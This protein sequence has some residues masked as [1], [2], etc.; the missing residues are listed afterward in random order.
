MNL[1]SDESEK[2][3]KKVISENKSSRKD[4]IFHKNKHKKDNSERKNSPY[5]AYSSNPNLTTNRFSVVEAYK[6]LRTNLQ[7]SMKKKGC[8]VIIITSTM[9]RD[10]K[11]TVAANI[12]VAF[13]Q[14]DIKV[15][16]IDCDMRKPRVNK[17]FN[18]PAIP[19]LSNLLAG[20][21]TLEQG[22]K[23]TEYKNLNI[24][25]SGILPP[26]P[27]ELLS[28]NDMKEL[29]DSLKNEYDL[30]I[31]D[32][33]PVNIVS[34]AI[35]ITAIADGV[36]LVVKHAVTT[37][38]DIERAIK[39]LEFVNAKLLGVVL[40]AVDYSKI[41]GKRYGYYYKGGKYGS[42]NRKDGYGAYESYGNN[43]SQPD[44]IKKSVSEE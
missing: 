24:I 4:V 32:T 34:D 1:N 33:P 21:C 31:L 38:P 17:F 41:Y 27:A 23:P 12:A 15:L 18:V 16:V 39:S 29:I 14:T 28:S 44:L 37:Y 8:N 36:V 13:A 3:A 19:G 9:P 7:F 26:N 10:G 22:I 11:S 35:A 30:I 5:G 25:T 20:L 43:S 40:N 2:V 42:Y 6:S